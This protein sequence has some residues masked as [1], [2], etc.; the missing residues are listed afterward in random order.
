MYELNVYCDQPQNMVELNTLLCQNILD[1]FNEHEV[2]IMTPAYRT[3]GK[4]GL[5]PGVN[6]DDTASLLDLM[7][8]PVGSARR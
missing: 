1:V 2:Q 6:I 5:L 3:Y 4:Q 7:E 8:T